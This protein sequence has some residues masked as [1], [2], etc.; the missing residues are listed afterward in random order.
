MSSCPAPRRLVIVW[1]SVWRKKSG[2]PGFSSSQFSANVTPL[3]TSFAAAATR[4]GVSRL[5]V[6]SWS[7]S[8]H[9]PHDERGGLPALKG[10]WSNEGRLALMDRLQF[11]CGPHSLVGDYTR[12]RRRQRM[13]F[14]FGALHRQWFQS[15]LRS[16]Q[17]DDDAT[18]TERG[19]RS[20]TLQKARH[21]ACP[22]DGRL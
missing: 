15:N 20:L 11:G 14:A 12:R 22:A 9:R 8:P 13:G 18:Q 21:A 16:G 4:S 17:I 19:Y 6:P 2:V 3:R 10:S 5:M 7:S 1:R